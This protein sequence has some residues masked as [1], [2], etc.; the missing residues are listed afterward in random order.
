MGAVS[1]ARRAVSVALLLLLAV[2]TACS[3]GGT[4]GQTQTASQSPASARP[5]L[6]PTSVSSSAT[7]TSASVTPTAGSSTTKSSDAPSLQA[8]APPQDLGDFT[9]SLVSAEA[10]PSATDTQCSWPTVVTGRSLDQW[11]H[12]E[13]PSQHSWCGPD[14][15]TQTSAWLQGWAY[16]SFPLQGT[17]WVAMHTCVGHQCPG[18]FIKCLDNCSAPDTA[19]R[20]YSVTVGTQFVLT[21]SNGLFVEEVCNVNT[22]SK[23]REVVWAQGCGDDTQVATNI[24]VCENEVDEQ[25]VIRSVN[26]IVVSLKLVSARPR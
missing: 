20:T 9:I 11:V 6:A 24:V 10:N 4:Q 17:T 5:S 13:E 3:N 21:T 8:V 7:T 19:P 12:L 22:S 25:G 23:D 1:S 15:E 26:N 2:L 14:A 16:P 18:T